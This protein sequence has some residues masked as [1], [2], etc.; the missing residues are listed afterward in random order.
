MNV[1]AA[2]QTVGL[3]IGPDYSTLLYFLLMT[4]FVLLSVMVFYWVYSIQR[5]VKRI[6]RELGMIAAQ[7][8]L[9]K[10]PRD[11]GKKDD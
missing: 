2:L 5:A 1:V 4:L 6:E 3:P 9:K 7:I 10:F 11:S 8:D